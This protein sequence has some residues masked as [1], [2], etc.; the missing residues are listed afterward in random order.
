MTGR[1]LWK[2][3]PLIILVWACYAN[4]SRFMKLYNS[5]KK[6]VYVQMTET[7]IQLIGRN[8]LTEYQYTGK[9]PKSDNFIPWLKKRFTPKK[10]RKRPIGVDYFGQKY[11]FVNNFNEEFIIIS[12]GPDKK[13]RTRDDIKGE[14]SIKESPSGTSPSK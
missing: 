2:I 12:K 6:A 1:I 13:L 11:L 7:E 14:F 9:L 10:R 5:M 8:I 3:V 4:T